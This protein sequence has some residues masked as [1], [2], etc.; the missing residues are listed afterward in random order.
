MG[1]L[2]ACTEV[3]DSE[4]LW[5][6][7]GAATDGGAATSGS[8]ASS[9]DTAAAAADAATDDGS[10]EPDEGDGDAAFDVGAGA[11]PDD[12]TPGCKK[13][14]FLFVVDDSGSMAGEQQN[15]LAS[16]PGFIETIE[17][18]ITAHDYQVL[19]TNTNAAGLDYCATLCAAPF[20]PDCQG[21]PCADVPVLDACDAAAGAGKVRD[22]NYQPCAFDTADR[23]LVDSQADMVGTFACVAEVGVRGNG[24]E[25]QATALVEAV[26][27]ELTGPGGC[28]EGFLRDDAILVV[29][30][31]TDEEDGQSVEGTDDDPGSPGTPEQW[32]DAVVAA[33][34]GDAEAVVVLGLVGDTDVE[35]GVCQPLDGGEGAEPAPVLRQFVQAFPHHVLGSVCA[36][37]YAPFFQAAVDVIDFACDEFDP[38]G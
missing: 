33:K 4:A 24:N 16:F 6:S 2:A 11:D 27:A 28:N 9:A 12:T 7:A 8:A 36:P 31:I 37:D 38:E 14:D 30:L 26:G 19:V 20:I 17:S 18:T 5:T 10:P 21:L 34:S 35:G 32:R 29:T 1:L 25:Q 3:R 13:V 15:L 22:Q 23:F